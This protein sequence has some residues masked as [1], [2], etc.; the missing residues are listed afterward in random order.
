MLSNNAP[1]KNGNAV[2]RREHDHDH[3]TP[4]LAT[5]QTLLHHTATIHTP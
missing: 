2:H 3:E 1:G 4:T 5:L